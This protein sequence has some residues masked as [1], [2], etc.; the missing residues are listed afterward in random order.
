[1][2]NRTTL[3]RIPLVGSLLC[4]LSTGFAQSISATLDSALDRTLDSMHL[5]LNNKSLNAALQM[6]NNYNWKHA[7]GISSINPPRNVTTDD[8]YLIGSVTKTITAACILQLADQHILNLD[9]SLYQWTDTIQY[10]NPN[11]TIRQLLRH[12]SGLYDALTNPQCFPTLQ[13]DPDSIWDA[14]DLI[15]TFIQPPLAQPGTT[16]KYCNTNYFLLGMIIRRATGYMFYMELRNRFF[17]PLG[18]NSIATPSW[19]TVSSPVAHA[20]MDITGDG[21]TD[22]AHS[23]YYNLLSLNSA[24][25]AAGC[26]YSNA[27][28]LSKWMR[29][30]MRG[31]L[32]SPAM[33]A[34]A[35]TTVTAPGLGSV[36]YGLGLMRKFFLGYEAYGHGGDLTYSAS[37]WYFPDFDISISVLNNEST[38]NSWGLIPVVTALLQTYLNWNLVN[39]VAE[40][41]TH[42]SSYSVFPNPFA[43]SFEL[44]FATKN[45]A[46]KIRAELVNLLGEKM[47]TQNYYSSAIGTGTIPFSTTGSLPHGLYFLNVYENESLVET[48]KIVK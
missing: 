17:I 45:P 23:F 43:E 22:D 15:T 36:T 9:D 13:N 3:L 48:L 32:L 47:C 41:Q 1:M 16:W 28:D 34:E 2:K 14:K 31:D 11:I 30:Y 25:G 8:V 39:G 12:E 38:V 26:Y 10:I 18:W 42:T 35:Q 7:T 4:I 33:M 40:H 5:V 19:E 20:W 21:V 27:A 6:P 24:G 46:T 29:T 44:T 37:S